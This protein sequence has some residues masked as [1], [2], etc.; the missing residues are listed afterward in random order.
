MSYLPVEFDLHDFQLSLNTMQSAN[1]HKRLKDFGFD[2]VQNGD[3]L[4]YGRGKSRITAFVQNGSSL[5]FLPDFYDDTPGGSVY[6][7]MEKM[8]VAFGGTMVGQY[9]IPS[10]GKT[11]DVRISGGM[12]LSGR[13]DVGQRDHVVEED[14]PSS[15]SSGVL[16]GGGAVAHQTTTQT[17]A[18]KPKGKPKAVGGGQ[19]SNGQQGESSRDKLYR[20]FVEETYQKHVQANGDDPAYFMQLISAFNTQFPKEEETQEASQV[21]QAIV[22]ALMDA[23][24]LDNAVHGH[25]ELGRELELLINNGEEIAINV[26]DDHGFSVEEVQEV[27]DAF[28]AQYGEEEEDLDSLDDDD[29]EEEDDE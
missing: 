12:N 19:V 25:K 21:D 17:V 15:P 3:T 5:N 11:W 14:D 23:I 18:A 6:A 9:S 27:I 13:P 29:W 20:V 22:D 1:F 4:V 24:G 28:I 26:A 2:S 8:C 10:L 7:I 16:P